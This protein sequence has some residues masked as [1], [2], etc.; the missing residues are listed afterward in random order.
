QEERIGRRRSSSSDVSRQEELVEAGWAGVQQTEPVT[1]GRNL[2]EG[3]D[4]AIDQELVAQDAI[5]IEQV[6]HQLS[7]VR[8][9]D[10]VIEHQRDIELG[11]AGQVEARGF[12]SRIQTVEQTI[13]P[14]QALVGVLRGKV[15][16]M[17]VVPER[18]Q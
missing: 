1:T 13:E 3:L 12:V 18:G 14:D 11:E 7:R 17:I 15:H 6:E 10:L 8:I 2:E 4:H 5:Q 16:A 9:E